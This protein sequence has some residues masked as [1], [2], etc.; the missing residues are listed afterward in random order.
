MS[1]QPLEQAI[2]AAKAVLAGVK[3]DQLSAP[4]PCKSW[5]VAGLVNH[6]VGGQ[7]FFATAVKGDKMPEG[8]APDYASGDFVAAFTEGSSAAVAAFN[9]DGAMEKI[10]KLPFGDMPGAAFVGI[11]ATDTFTH[12]WDLAKATGQSTDLL[13][14]LAA[15]LLEAA[16]AFIPES[17]RGPEPAAF[18]PIQTAPAG[19]T[20]A[21]ELAA[22][23]GRAV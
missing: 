5:D 7:Y 4:T 22:F 14:D 3:P 19:A 17:F 23:L 2:T 8:D 10:L 16:K 1:T 18:G 20:K 6:L 13:P 15:G 9:S 12:T 21:D 11:A